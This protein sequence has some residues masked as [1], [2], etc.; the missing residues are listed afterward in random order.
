MIME[1]V[2]ILEE[3]ERER[4]N[5]VLASRYHMDIFQKGKMEVADEILSADFTLINPSLPPEI[6]YGREG[7]KK[8]AGAVITALPDLKITHDDILAKGDKVMIRWTVTGTQ[9]GELFGAPS[10]G[11]RMTISGFDLF[12]ISKD[13]I[14]DMWQ[15]HTDDSW[16]K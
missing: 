7:T 3:R 8:F 6:R 11:K 10:T 14:I 15:L 5:E 2:S 12:R 4:Q 9:T 13:K 1:K 16:L